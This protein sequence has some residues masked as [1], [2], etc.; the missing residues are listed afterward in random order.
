MIDVL[1]NVLG[2]ATL[3]ELIADRNVTSIIIVIDDKSG[4]QNQAVLYIAT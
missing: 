1:S 3:T 4:E 2:S